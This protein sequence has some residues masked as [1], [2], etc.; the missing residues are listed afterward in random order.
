M[1]LNLNLRITIAAGISLFVSML[2]TGIVSISISHMHEFLHGDPALS[3]LILTSYSLFLCASILLFG[4]L[5]SQYSNLVIFKLGLLMFL[6]T[7]ILCTLSWSMESL[8]CLRSF[9]GI[10]AAML[11]ATALALI[12]L[13]VTQEHQAKVMTSVIAISS[14]GPLVAPALGG[15][16]IEHLSWEWMFYLNVP[17]C[18]CSLIAIKPIKQKKYINQQKKFTNIISY[19]LCI[20]LFCVGILFSKGY[21]FFLLSALFLALSLY[22]DY[23]SSGSG[24]GVLIH[25]DILSPKYYLSLCFFI[26]LGMCTAFLFIL[27]P[28]KL[29][30]TH[31]MLTVSIMTMLLP[32]S[33]M[34]TAKLSS[35]FMRAFSY[36]ALCYTGILLMLVGIIGLFT[37]AFVYPYALLYLIL[38]GIG[39]G[40]FQPSNTL[41]LF[42]YAKVSAHPMSNSLSR[43]GLNLGIALSA[44]LISSFYQHVHV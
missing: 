29:L 18:L 24:H 5:S 21:M 8:I 44:S 32:L 30:T 20:L 3:P 7:S 39:A 12:S 34:I 27:A 25:Y 33:K 35:Y 13:Y 23:K 17:L 14:A 9:Q 16:I 6:C 22:L 36:E 10:A 19:T 41:L 40:L 11:Q 42:K 4:Y 2:D 38:F 31:N 26:L 28:M 15:L 43:L 37:D 1:N